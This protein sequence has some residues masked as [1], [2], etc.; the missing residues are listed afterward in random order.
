[1]PGYSIFKERSPRQRR[2]AIDTGAR[3]ASIIYD[4]GAPA[5]RRA[6]TAGAKNTHGMRMAAII[7]SDLSFCV[8]HLR[9]A[10]TGAARGRVGFIPTIVPSTVGMNPTLRR[11]MAFL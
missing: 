9:R 10:K 5:T 2:I 8:C 3:P 4:G 6:R 11:A 1:L 7:F